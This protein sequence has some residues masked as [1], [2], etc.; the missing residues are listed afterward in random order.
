MGRGI[1]NHWTLSY[2]RWNVSENNE[3][4]NGLQSTRTLIH[5]HQYFRMSKFDLSLVNNVF[6]YPFFLFIARICFGPRRW[7]HS[8]SE[9]YIY[10]YYIHFVWSYKFCFFFLRSFFLL[11]FYTLSVVCVNVLILY[12]L[13]SCISNVLGEGT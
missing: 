10:I 5:I 3:V 7:Y 9:L 12:N 11:Y 1:N 8:V 2:Y 6:W 4:R 13:K